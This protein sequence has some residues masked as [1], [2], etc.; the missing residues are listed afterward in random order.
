MLG[1]Q[2]TKV[3]CTARKKTDPVEVLGLLRCEKDSRPEKVNPRLPVNT[4]A[5]SF[6]CPDT[7]RHGQQAPAPTLGRTMDT[8]QGRARAHSPNLQSEFTQ[9]QRT[10]PTFPAS[11]PDPDSAPSPLWFRHPSDAARRSLKVQ[12]PTVPVPR[13]QMPSPPAWLIDSRAPTCG[14]LL[15][16]W[17]GE[18]AC[19]SP[20]DARV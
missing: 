12:C 16:A 6:T 11:S 4:D 3:A 1:S 13:Q 8:G 5:R 17:S 2:P 18:R 19:V 20:R 10:L 14:H 9:T 7:F 15:R